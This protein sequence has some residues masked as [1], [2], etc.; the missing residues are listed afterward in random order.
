[1]GMQLPALDI[2]FYIHFPDLEGPEDLGRIL[3]DEADPVRFVDNAMRHPSSPPCCVMT[4]A[5]GVTLDGTPWN[6]DYDCFDRD[7]P[8]VPYFYMNAIGIYVYW[9]E[10]ASEML[11]GATEYEAPTHDDEG[12]V[13][14]FRSRRDQVHFVWREIEPEQRRVPL[15]EFGGLLLREGK[16]LFGFSKMVIT[17]LEQRLAESGLDKKALKALKNRLEEVRSW[18]LPKLIGDLENALASKGQ[19]ASLER[20]WNDV[21]DLI[22]D[23]PPRIEAQAGTQGGKAVRLVTLIWTELPSEE[24]PFLD[25]LVERIGKQGISWQNPFAKRKWKHYLEE[26]GVSAGEVRLILRT[27]AGR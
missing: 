6:G 11:R 9:L 8:L 19:N 24:R 23:Y 22:K 13:R 26:F 4:G 3:I 2:H 12:A 16:K 21:L 27:V 18:Q 1:M 15:A 7:K 5:F 17:E 25:A 14:F 10:A 20:A